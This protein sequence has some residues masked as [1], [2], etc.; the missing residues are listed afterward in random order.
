MT[1][2]QIKPNILKIQF[3]TLFES[4]IKWIIRTRYVDLNLQYRAKDSKGDD[5]NSG[6]N[7]RN[8]DPT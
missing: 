6:K 7:K 1:I 8:N 3:M 4:G 2:R 5:P